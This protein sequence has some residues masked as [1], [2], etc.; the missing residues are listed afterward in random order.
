MLKG[1]GAASGVWCG[2]GVRQGAGP[3]RKESVLCLGG[4]IMVA[5]PCP[6]CPALEVRPANPSPPSLPLT[7]TGKA[8]QPPQ[9]HLRGSH[10]TLSTLTVSHPAPVTLPRVILHQAHLLFQ[11]PSNGHTCCQSSCIVH[12]S[13]IFHPSAAT[14]S[15]QSPCTSHTCCHTLQQSHHL[16]SSDRTTSATII[17]QYL[18]LHNTPVPSRN[19]LAFVCSLLYEGATSVRLLSTHNIPTI[20]LASSSA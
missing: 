9:P 4:D 8:T 12:T 13:P 17:T 18:S 7:H 6:V 10:P 19:L 5:L 2:R 11:S 20:S 3:G 15:C 14:P 16:V 1:E